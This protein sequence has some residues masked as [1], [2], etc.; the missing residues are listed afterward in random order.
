MGSPSPSSA[1]EHVLIEA[2][3]LSADAE[4]E[5]ETA[6]SRAASVEDDSAPA[7]ARS[8]GTVIGHSQARSVF[9]AKSD[10]TRGRSV[11]HLRSGMR[12]RRRRA[13]L[14][15]RCRDLHNLSD[16]ILPPLPR[17]RHGDASASSRAMLGHVTDVE[18]DHSYPFTPDGL[19]LVTVSSLPGRPTTES[20]GPPGR[21]PFGPG[22][23]RPETRVSPHER[24][25]R[26]DRSSRRS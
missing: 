3:F 6:S 4:P 13:S 19:F 1:N 2:S 20:T 16:A 9:P 25:T 24:P 18:A 23:A 22:S 10:P 12:Y 21:G 8:N 7:R 14:H 17:Q 5:N 26:E 11:P 15:T